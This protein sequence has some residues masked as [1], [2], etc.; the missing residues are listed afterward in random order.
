M[1]TFENINNLLEG[2][3]EMEE[4]KITRLTEAHLDEVLASMRKLGAR[5]RLIEIVNTL[6]GD[7]GVVKTPK[8]EEVGL[9][10]I[11]VFEGK[12]KGIGAMLDDPF[13]SLYELDCKG[14]NLYLTNDLV[15]GIITRK[16]DIDGYNKSRRFNKDRISCIIPVTEGGWKEY[17]SSYVFITKLTNGDSLTHDQNK[18][19]D[20]NA[21]NREHNPN[22]PK[23]HII[24]DEFEIKSHHAPIEYYGED[25]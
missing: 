7:R 17:E 22:N 1:F 4:L 25:C 3:L 14:A 15:G 5:E 10:A 23:H 21:P 12:V 24:P 8:G 16:R 11:C 20:L 2:K 18:I 6:V 9:N 13:F 19:I